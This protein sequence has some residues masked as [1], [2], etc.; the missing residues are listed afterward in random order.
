MGVFN[1][2]KNIMDK[3]SLLKLSF[4]FLQKLKYYIEITKS[5]KAKP[6]DAS[7]GFAC[8]GIRPIPYAAVSASLI[9]KSFIVSS[10][11]RT[12]GANIVV[13]V[14]TFAGMSTSVSF[15]PKFL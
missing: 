9:F 10:N 14:L 8:F 15:S 7:D 3:Y 6:L 2:F 13:I 11:G 5:P 4:I 12:I 1:A